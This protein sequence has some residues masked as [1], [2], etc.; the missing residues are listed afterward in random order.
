MIRIKDVRLREVA[1]PLR[2]TFSTSLGQKRHLHSVIVKVVLDDGS[3]GLGEVP[4]SFAFRDET[5]PVIGRVLREAAAKI[6]GA[7]I[8]AYGPLVDRLRIANPV[9]IMSISGLEA[10]LFRAFLSTRGLS[11][12]AYWGD[13]SDRLET[14]ITIP[15]LTDE[16]RL[17][18]W[19]DWTVSR[20]FKTYKLKVSGSVEQDRRIVSL[21]HGLLNARVPGFRLR[22]DGNQ[23]YT[24][25]SFLEM[26]HHIEKMGL[27]IELFEQPLRKDDFR[28]FEEI[29]PYTAIPIILDESIVTL[30]DARRAID[31]HLMDGLNIKLAKSGVA[32]SLKIAELARL[33]NMKLMIGCMTETMVGLSAAVFFAAGTGFFDFVDLDSVHLLFGKNGW[34]GLTI[35]GP[36]FAIDRGG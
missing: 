23:G 10:A 22:L 5:L 27:E 30:T 33:N 12:H 31:N 28:G 29:R 25:A 4:T 11:E 1:R 7:S 2:T 14:D 26:L 19:I 18:R 17:L 21:L 15:F 32:G 8:D 34:P 35:E 13:T 36:A 24:A 16:A 3:S 20:G 6:R 9:A